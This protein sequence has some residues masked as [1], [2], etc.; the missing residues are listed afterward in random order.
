MVLYNMSLQD[1]FSFLFRKEFPNCGH[2][3]LVHLSR[4]SIF[5]P[6]GS[7]D[8]SVHFLLSVHSTMGTYR[9][10]VVLHINLVS[11]DLD[12]G[13]MSTFHLYFISFFF[14][15]YFRVN[16]RALHKVPSLAT[17]ILQ[18]DES[19]LFFRLELMRVTFPML[20]SCA[21]YTPIVM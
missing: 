21:R 10:H 4:T 11:C 20:D 14:F 6:T 5:S 15:D 1:T 2:C 12:V 19:F 16:H 17:M 9:V 8:N 18:S 3:L 13:V 7:P